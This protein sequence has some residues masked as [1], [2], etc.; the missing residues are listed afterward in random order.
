MHSTRLIST[1]FLNAGYWRFR[2]SGIPRRQPAPQG[3]LPRPGVCVRP[4][5]QNLALT[6]EFA[7]VSRPGKVTVVKDRYLS[8]GDRFD[9]VAI[10]DI[11][12]GDFTAALQ[13]GLAS[14]L[15]ESLR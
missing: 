12:T 4:N 9:V 13:G 3:R 11:V 14:F 5:T 6:Y 10:D 7:S 15:T 8:H 2:V 1:K